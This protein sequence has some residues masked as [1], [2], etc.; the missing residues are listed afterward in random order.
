MVQSPLI[1][2][3][4]FEEPLKLDDRRKR[5][6]WRFTLVVFMRLLACVW[7]FKGLLWW[8][9]LI[10]IGGGVSFEKLRL[11]ARAIAIGF[12]IIDLVAAVGLWMV[13]SWGGVIWLLS[14]TVESVLGVLTPRL[15]RADSLSIY[16]NVGLIVAYLLFT[17]KAAREEEL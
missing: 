13:S 1:P 7:L 17:S 10:G 3:D 6:G 2:N 12:A 15:M 5:H 9:D 4:P 11:G 16:I 14:V 8:G